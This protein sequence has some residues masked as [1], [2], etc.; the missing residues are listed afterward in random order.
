MRGD[1]DAD[2]SAGLQAAVDKAGAAPAGGIVLVPPGR[3]LVTKTIYVWRAVRLVGYGP[4]RPMLVLPAGTPGFQTGL[5]VMALFTSVRQGQRVPGGVASV[6][7]GQRP[8][9]RPDC[10]RQPGHVLSGDDQHRLRDWRRQSGGGRDPLPRRA[11][12]HPQPHGLRRGLRPRALTQIGNEVRTSTFYGGRFGILT[13][14]TSPYWPFTLLDSV[15]DGQREAAIREHM[16]GLTVVRSTFR[17][18]PVGIEIARDYSDQLWVKDTR[19]ENVSQRR[20]RHQQREERDDAGRRSPTRRAPACRCSRAS[21]RAARPRP[22][23][24]RSIASTSFNH[25]LVVPPRRH[26]R[27]S[28]RATRRPAGDAAGAAAAGDP[29]AAA[30]GCAGSTFGRSAS[31][32]TAQTDDTDAIRKAIDVASR[33]VLP[34]RLLR[35][36][37]HDHAQARHRRSSRCIRARRSSIFPT[38]RPA[39][40]AW[41]RPRRCSRRRRAGRNIVAGLGHLHRRHQPARD[42]RPVDGGRGVAARTTF[43][44]TA[45]RAAPAASRC[46]RRSTAR[47]RAGGQPSRRDDGARSIRACG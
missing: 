27:A 21:A 13:E 25:G 15:F 36:P 3:Y 23:R 34:D 41:A 6:A 33:A 29:A 31:R 17:N 28:T 42:R 20:R 47:W 44:S 35:R 40:R 26:R 32:A 9:E 37:R 46:G 1:D 11:A 30:D 2:D 4:T 8:A 14:N 43:N 16:A 18:V 7:A 10:R 19:F 12:R 38:A 45:S 22:A 5:G 39:T 24:A